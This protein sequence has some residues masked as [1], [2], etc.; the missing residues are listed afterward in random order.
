MPELDL[1]VLNENI[2]FV[3]EILLK[4]LYNIDDESLKVYS[5]EDLVSEENL[6]GL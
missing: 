3:S 5:K 1:K 4:F 6:K 2:R